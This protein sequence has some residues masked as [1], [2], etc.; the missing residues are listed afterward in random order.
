MKGEG[1]VERQSELERGEVGRQAS[2]N[3][4][5]R[6]AALLFFHSGFRFCFQNGFNINNC[7]DIFHPHMIQQSIV[8]F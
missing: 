6:K 3:R 5:E 2:S 8:L 4:V 1:E 7:V